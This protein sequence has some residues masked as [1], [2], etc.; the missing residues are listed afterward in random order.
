[1]RSIWIDVHTH[2]SN[3]GQDGKVRENMLKDL[4]NVLDRS[5]TDLRFVVSCDVPYI[6]RITN[7]PSQML[8][9]NK[10]IYD[11]VR[12]A[13]DRLYGACMINPNYLEEALHVMDVCFK[14]WGFVILGEMLQ[15]AMNYRMDSDKVERIVRLATEYDVPVQVHLGTYWHRKAGSS[16][17]GMDHMADL[18]GIADRVPEAKYILA[19]AIGCGPTPEYIS[20]ADMFLDTIAGVF[21]SY[22]RNFW[23]EIRDFQCRA[24]RRTIAE[25]PSDRLLAGTDWTTR[26]GPPFQSYGTMFGVE[27]SMNPFPPKIE[28]FINFLR[29]AGAS[30]CAI[31]RIAFENA[32]ELLKLEI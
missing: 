8:A 5:G 23:I 25:V 32:R 29:K 9:A 19:H 4:L 14:E 13:P 16:G 26:F 6:D 18:L 10:M 2:V 7:D 20:W 12:L 30:D 11:L 28:S 21:P 22:P 1:M 3:I 24:L 17:S 31:S 27:E 15:Y